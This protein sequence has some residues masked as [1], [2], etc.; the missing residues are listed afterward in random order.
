MVW[1]F[2]ESNPFGGGASFTSTVG[3]ISRLFVSLP[4]TTPGHSSQSDATIQS[5]GN[6]KVISTDPPYYD[7]IGYADLSD[8]FYVWLRRSLKPVLPELSRRSPCPRPMS[9]S[10]RP[11]ATAAR[12]RQ[13]PSSW[14]A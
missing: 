11:I 12:R 3:T 6:L 9:W 7:N 4:A 5:L 14:R 8:Y 1:D 2:A 13:R 10:L